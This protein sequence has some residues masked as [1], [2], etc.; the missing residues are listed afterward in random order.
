MP[1]ARQAQSAIFIVKVSKPSPLKGPCSALRPLFRLLNGA[2]E[3][4]K[5]VLNGLPQQAQSLV[6]KEELIMRARYRSDWLRRLLS[7]FAILATVQSTSRADKLPIVE[8][9]EFQ[10]LSAQVKRIIEALEMLGQPLE[11]DEKA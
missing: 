8:S 4:V 9:V 7:V 6:V 3:T 11:R 1:A 5:P 2:S 10:P